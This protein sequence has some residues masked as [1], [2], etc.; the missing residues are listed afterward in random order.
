MA[1]RPGRSSTIASS[2]RSPDRWQPYVYF[3]QSR[4]TGRRSRSTPTAC[5]PP[6]S[7]PHGFRR[8][9]AGPPV[10][11]LMLGGSSLWGFG[12]RDD[13]TIPSLLARKLH[14]RGCRR[15]DQEPLRDRLRQHPGDDRPGRASFSGLPA[16]LVIFYDGVND[17]TSALL[18]GEADAHHQRDQPASAS[19]I[20]C[21][22]RRGCGR[23]G[24]RPRRRIPALTGSPSRSA[25]D[26]WRRPATATRRSP[27]DLAHARRGVVRR[28]AANVA[29][30]EPWARSTASA[31]C[32]SGSRSSSPSRAGP[33]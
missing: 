13:Q 2:R 8:S 33:L 12:A 24:R 32:S 4:F 25:G 21:N 20:S 11:I 17:T 28:Y 18:E 30:V 16:G 7:L 3:R 19:S 14:E 6:G 26:S 22:R 31:R 1:E 15:R 27:E 29:I 23:A 10:K 5:A 9:E